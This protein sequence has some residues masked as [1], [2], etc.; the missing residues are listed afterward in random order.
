M[1]LDFQSFA[2]YV[3]VDSML[4]PPPPFSPLSPNEP[5]PTEKGRTH[6]HE[7]L[8]MPNLYIQRSAIRASGTKYLRKEKRNYVASKGKI[9]T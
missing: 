7:N 2:R 5:S 4:P 9:C 8:S 3:P 6:T 1:Y